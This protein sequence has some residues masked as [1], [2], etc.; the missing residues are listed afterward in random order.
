MAAVRPSTPVAA[1]TASTISAPP[2][3]IRNRLVSSGKKIAN[4]CFLKVT[5][6]GAVIHEN[7]EVTGPTRAATFEDEKATGPLMLQGDHGPVAYRNLR[8]KRSRRTDAE[9]RMRLWWPTAPGIAFV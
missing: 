8:L 4:A 7:V 6:N 3:R 2:R 5:H 9:M 1:T